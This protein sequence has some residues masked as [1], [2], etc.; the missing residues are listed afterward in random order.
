MMV[1]AERETVGG[2]VVLADGKWNQVG[3]VD[4]ADVVAGGE[5]DAEAAGGALVVVDGEDFAAEGG[6][7]AVFERLVCDVEIRLMSDDCWFLIFD[8][9]RI[10]EI[11]GDES[12]AHE[13]AVCGNGDEVLE[14]IGEAGEGLADVLDGGRGLEGSL[15]AAIVDPSLPET[16]FPQIEEGIFRGVFIVVFADE[17]ETGSEA[18]A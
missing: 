4:K 14:A 6:A 13:V 7:A 10:G 9:K 12:L 16:V 2:V 5:L 11:A 15:A 17:E 8:W 1:F 18:V 3:G